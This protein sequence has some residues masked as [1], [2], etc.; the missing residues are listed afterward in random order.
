MRYFS[1]ND[2]SIGLYALKLLAFRRN[3]K[4]VEH[5]A[6]D[7]NYQNNPRGYWVLDDNDDADGLNIEVRFGDVMHSVTP[8][9]AL[10]ILMTMIIKVGLV[11]ERHARMISCRSRLS[12]AA[13]DA[14]A[15]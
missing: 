7:V 12:H 2:Q 11:A 13:S 4:E 8:E 9:T 5:Y 10:R 6:L 3:S 14:A 1:G 15:G